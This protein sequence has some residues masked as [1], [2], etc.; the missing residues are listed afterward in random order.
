MSL[1]ISIIIGLIVLGLIWWVCDMLPI[2][3]NFKKIIHVILIV[4]VIVWLLNVL[5]GYNNGY[6]SYLWHR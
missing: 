4:I 3:E 6:H 1:L 5:L 2:P